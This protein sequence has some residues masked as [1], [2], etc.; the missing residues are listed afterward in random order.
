VGG[1]GVVAI[2]KGNNPSS[3]SV[4]LRG[5]MDALPIE[6]KTGVEY[7]SKNKG[8]MHACGHDVHTTCLLGAAKI[9][10]ELK[11]HWNGTLTLVFQPAEEKLPGGASIMLKEGLFSK[12][13]PQKMLAQH[14]FPELPVG[15]V[16]ITPGAYMASSDELYITVKGK[17]GHGAKPDHAVDPVL[18]ASHLII[19][20]Q[21]VV[22]RWS[23]PITPSVLTIGKVNANGATNVIPSEVTME[24]TF[25]TF[26][27][28]WRSD[29]HQRMIALAK[30]L[31]EGMGGTVEF[32]VE[33]GYP[34]VYNDPEVTA[35]SRNIAE[36]YLGKDNVVTLERRATAEDFAYFSQVVPGCFY[37]LGTASENGDNR[38]S[39]H[40]PQFNIDEKAIELGMGLM[41]YMAIVE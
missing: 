21:Q 17:G 7:Q 1:E 33:R 37:R 28:N 8:I 3:R 12:E 9:L 19:A 15:K 5:D 35:V 6:E 18:I 11:D 30:G 27:E 32:R 13:K 23:N 2:V 26:D 22:S 31:V 38:F 24:G 25:R 16:G 10:N 40:H 14:V 36:D 39:V 29:A 20:L 4:A 34:V 41:A